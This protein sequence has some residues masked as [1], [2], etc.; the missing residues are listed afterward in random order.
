MAERNS[1]LTPYD[2]M[3]Q[4]SAH[5]LMLLRDKP[6][7]LIAVL[8]IDDV[9]RGPAVGGIRTLRYAS[10][11]KAFQDAQKLASAMTLKTAIA[12]LPAGG[13]KTVVIDHDGFDRSAG[14]R[15]LGEFI[16]DLGGLYRAAGDLGTTAQDLQ[17]A[18]A[19]TSFV[20]TQGENLGD[21]TGQ[22]VVECI[23]ALAHSR[24]IGSLTGLRVAIQGC[25][26]IGSGVARKLSQ[27]GARLIVTDVD[28]AAAE[29]LAQQVGAEVV[30]P[31]EILFAPVDIVAPCAIGGVITSDVVT[32]MRA[33]GICGGANN[34]LADAAALQRLTERDILFMPD[35]LSSAGAVV[36]GAAEALMGGIDPAPLI[37]RLG[38]TAREVL[39]SASAD[40]STVAV[41]T[42]IARGRIEAVRSER[43]SRNSTP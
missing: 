10:V 40:Q 2:L 37:R 20:N 36:A 22:G 7:G 28:R 29:K 24:G 43:A 38:D 41:A 5:R 34:Q 19:V 21:F 13:A 39:A 1:P 16:E 33:W 12:D 3:D 15:R 18:A 26:V 42:A 8:A 17:T 14:F 6:S 27:A 30:A 4:A 23:N 31:D 25:G 11:A 32:R 35:F 9:T